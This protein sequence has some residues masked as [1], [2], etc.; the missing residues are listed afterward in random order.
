M[1]LFIKIIIIIFDVLE[2]IISYK[3]QNKR[4]VGIKRRGKLVK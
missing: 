4:K 1:D 3:F 2:I